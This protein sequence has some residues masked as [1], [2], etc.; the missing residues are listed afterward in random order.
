M[1]QVT[2][3]F[4]GAYLA[5]RLL[6]KW[7]L[8]LNSKV[9]LS[10]LVIML[11]EHHWLVSKIF[12]TSI[13]S[14]ELPRSVLIALGFCY[15][16]LL[17]GAVLIAIRD[18]AGLALLLSTKIIGRRVLDSLRL[19]SAI[20][21]V[22][23]LASALSVYEAIRVPRVTTLEVVL[24]HL[25]VELDGYKM[26]LLTDLH[27]SRLLQQSWAQEVVTKT[28]SLNA[29]LVVISGDLV[30][31][32]LEDRAQDVE[33][34]SALQAPDGVFA[35]SGNHEYYADYLSW[36]ARFRELGISFLENSH[37]VIRP[38]KGGFVLA[39]VPDQVS[40][41]FSQTP[42][43]IT[44]ALMGKPEGLPVVLLDHRPG[45]MRANA[46]AGADLQLSGHT[47]GGHIRGVDLVVK[48][49]NNGFVS[50]H[51]Q[52]GESTLYVSNGAGLW[53]GLPLRLGRPSEITLITL[54]SL[55]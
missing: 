14:P 36:M 20:L 32:T 50:G 8:A 28:N 48:A 13:P 37:V 31:G 44:K 23:V 27:L 11:I 22:S 41:N 49:F 30:D 16:V 29:N 24:P 51:Y 12:G 52:V 10:V 9:V 15:G 35:V 43:D 3:F 38:D 39:G 2:N 17:I 54:R 4:I 21:A 7:S 40:T 33:P 1:F 42:P 19:T 45:A 46:M 18:L 53:P 5:W 6:A 25:P 47:H 34:L 26:A 55:G